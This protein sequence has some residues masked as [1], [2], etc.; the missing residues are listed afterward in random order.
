M[1][2]PSVLVDTYIVPVGMHKNTLTVM[3]KRPRKNIKSYEHLPNCAEMC[4]IISYGSQDC[5]IC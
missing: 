1:N 2:A 4:F 3:G 5:D